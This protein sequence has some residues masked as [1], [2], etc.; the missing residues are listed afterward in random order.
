MKI[1]SGKIGTPKG[2]TTF[3][4]KENM[5]IL[6]CVACAF[7]VSSEKSLPQSMSMSFFLFS[8]RSLVTVS[9]LTSKS[10]HFELIFVSRVR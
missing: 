5:F 8:S 7:D 10:L 4:D 6:A 1:I 2:K 3:P 9:G